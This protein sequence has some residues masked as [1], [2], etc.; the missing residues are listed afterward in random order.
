M[1][2]NGSVG[3]VSTIICNVISL[4]DKAEIAALY[5][6]EKYSVALWFMLE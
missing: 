4:V 2:N 3:V 5:L 1:I 6:N